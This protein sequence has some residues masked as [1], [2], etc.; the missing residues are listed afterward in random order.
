METIG[1][2]KLI[3][4]LGAIDLL[5]GDDIT[6]G[7]L[8]N[9][10]TATAGELIETIGKLRHSVA[11]E[12]Q[13][14]EAPTHWAGTDSVNIYD[15]LDQLMQCVAQLADHCA[16]HKH[17]VGSTMSQAPDIASNMTARKNDANNLH[18]TLNPLVAEA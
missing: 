2:K 11:V 10:H 7:S 15:L 5:A 12:L 1:G 8:G 18:S 6:L 4:A 3:E 13:R 14:I 17:L 16:S 9:M